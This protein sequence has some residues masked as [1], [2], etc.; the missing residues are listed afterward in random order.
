MMRLAGEGREAREGVRMGIWG[1][2][3]AVAFGLGGLV[4]AAAADLARLWISSAGTAYALVFLLE[5]LMFLV[6]ARLAWRIGAAP[7][8]PAVRGAQGAP[9]YANAL[10]ARMEHR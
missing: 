7:N 5:G 1:A 6:A 4:G 9:A 2:A 3:Q 8:A 10:A